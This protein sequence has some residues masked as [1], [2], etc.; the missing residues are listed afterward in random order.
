MLPEPDGLVVDLGCGE[1]RVARELESLG[2]RVVGVDRSPALIRAALLAAP[3]IPV[4]QADCASGAFRDGCAALVV[5]CMV[6]LDVDDLDGTVREAHRLPADGG[7]LCIAL[8]HPF[9]SA[10]AYEQFDDDVP[11]FRD[12]YLDER[13]TEIR[14]SIMSWAIVIRP[15]AT[16]ASGPARRANGERVRVAGTG[17][18]IDCKEADRSR[19]VVM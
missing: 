15:P 9:S 14:G 18:R 2:Y 13:R 11:T 12:P 6:L 16:T 5:A 7:V 3:A 17:T 4:V 8:T 1:G 10:Q 19:V